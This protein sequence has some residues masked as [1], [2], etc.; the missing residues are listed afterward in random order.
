MKFELNSI[1]QRK[2]EFSLFQCRQKYYEQGE[3]ARRFLAQRVKQQFNRTLITSVENENGTLVTNRGEINES[4]KTFYQKLYTSQ[5]GM[6]QEEIDRFLSQVDLP[7][8]SEEK[9]KEIGGD[10]TLEEVQQA[11]RKISSGKAP[12]NDGL[13]I[14]FYKEFIDLLA[15]RLV[16]VFQDAVKGVICQRACDLQ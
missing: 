12:G 4:F 13:P 7:T 11:I 10:I 6:E 16:T 2:A 8:L 1:L 9:L 15:P 3:A 14:D 5:G